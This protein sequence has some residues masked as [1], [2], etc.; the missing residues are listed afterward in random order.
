MFWVT[1]GNPVLGIVGRHLVG[2]VLLRGLD[3]QYRVTTDSLDRESRVV[4]I[5]GDRATLEMDAPA[6]SSATALSSPPPR[7]TKDQSLNL[8]RRLDVSLLG[9]VRVTETGP[10]RYSV[11]A[12]DVQEVLEHTGQVLA[13]A[14]PMV[15]PLISLQDGVTFQVR[16]PVSDGVFESRGFRVTSPNLAQRAGLQSGDL[17]LAVNGQAVNGFGDLYRLYQQVRKDPRLSLVEVSLERQG[18]LVTK[19]YRIR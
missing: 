11:N 14:W 2:T 18:V 6:P 9:R 16:S 4:D 1:Q 5:Y 7:E 19:S 8:R 10:D 17:I 13:E 3:Y 12:A 15:S